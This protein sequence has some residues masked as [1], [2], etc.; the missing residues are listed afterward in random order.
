MLPVILLLFYGFAVYRSPQSFTRVVFSSIMLTLSSSFTACVIVSALFTPF[1]YELARRRRPLEEALSEIPASI[2]HPVVGIA[3][4]I[5]D[6][7]LTP[8]GKAL[9]SIGI[10]FFDSY[11][12]LVIALVTVSAPIYIRSLHSF[13]ESLPKEP[14]LFAMSLGAPRL[15]VLFNVVLPNSYRGVLL[16]FLISMSRAMSEFG[17]IAILAYYVLQPPF[18]GVSPA[19]VLI[20]DFYGYYGPTV[21]VT[22]A[23]LLVVVSLPFAFA[24]RLIK[25]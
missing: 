14:E 9:Q 15:K 5:L 17:S 3:L 8:T 2:P 4:L 7:P 20:Y 16:S 12:G 11:L 1:A 19:S 22:T 13:F 18:N 23:A 6:S 10:N 21:A 24:A 25:R